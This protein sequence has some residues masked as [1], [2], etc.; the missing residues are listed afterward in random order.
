VIARSAGGHLRSGIDE[1]DAPAACREPLG[2]G[3]SGQPGADHQ[4]LPCMRQ[5][6]PQG[7]IGRRHMRG[8][9]RPGRGI[10]QGQRAVTRFS[11]ESDLAHRRRQ[12]H[13]RRTEHQR[14]RPGP[15][16]AR[17]ALAG[18]RMPGWRSWIEAGRVGMQVEQVHRCVQPG[19]LFFHR[20][21]DQG[22][23]DAA[24]IEQEAV[25]AR[26]WQGHAARKACA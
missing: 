24:F 2:G 4:G 25:R 14:P 1:I 12:R 18:M 13:I 10:T 20:A 11:V 6:A 9:P 19:Q 8:R 15:G 21:P 17:Q 3:R 7:R 5:I 16:Q 22:Q 26:Q 23:R